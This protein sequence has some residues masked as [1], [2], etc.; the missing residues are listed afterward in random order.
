MRCITLGLALALALLITSPAAAFYEPRNV[1]WSALEQDPLIAQSLNIAI[2]RWHRL[3]PGCSRP[4]TPITN[5]GRL[6]LG[7][8]EYDGPLHENV[9][10]GEVVALTWGTCAIGLTRRFY[11]HTTGTPGDGYSA[12]LVCVAVVHEYGHVLGKPHSRNPRSVMYPILRVR[13]V[14]ACRTLAAQPR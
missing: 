4:G 3:P 12:A 5:D 10:Q 1:A 7:V 9:A 8:F 14:P 6:P 11:H 13:N 2:R